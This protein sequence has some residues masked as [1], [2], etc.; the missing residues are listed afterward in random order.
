MS[1]LTLTHERVDDIPLLVKLGQALHLDTAVD[2]CLGTHGL[3]QG[4]SN[5]QLVVVWLAYILSESDHC[6]SRVEEWA[7]RH[8]QTLER[9][10]KHPV[11]RVDF[12]DDRLGNLLRRLSLNDRWE[13]LEQMVWEGEVQVY[14]LGAD[15]VRLDSTTSAGHHQVREKGWMQYG[16]SKDHRPD[17]PQL[18]LMAALAEPAGQWIA[19]DVHP[20][21]RADEGLYLPLYQRVRKI[22]GQQ[23]LLYVGDCKMAPLATRAQMAAQGDY[24][25][26]RLPRNLVSATQWEEWKTRRD[27]M[28]QVTVFWEEEQVVGAG[29]EWEETLSATVGG[30]VITWQERLQWIYSPTLAQQQRQGL[31]QRLQQ[32]REALLALTPEPGRGKRAIRD[33]ETLRSRSTAILERYQVS[34]LLSLQWEVVE[35]R[36]TRYV[37]RG[38]GSTNRPVRDIIRQYYRITG[39]ER[40]TAAIQT[41]QNDFGWQLQITNAPVARLALPQAAAVY[42]NQWHVEHDF[43]RVKA[44]PV[45]L[46]PLFVWRD[47]QVCG[48][49]RLLILAL[50]LLTLIETQVARGLMADA[51]SLSGL[52]EAQPRR[53]TNRPSAVR[54]LRAL[55][56]AE[57]TLTEARSPTHSEWY[58]SPLPPW[59]SQVLAY[60]KLPSDLYESL[61]ENSL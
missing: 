26:T 38:R 39:V 48:L 24:Y 8:R 13:A 53:T 20:G 1:N 9:L 45:G 30:Q 47:D 33:E 15:T 4:L 29:C 56:R 14:A 46:S 60:L 58:L 7:W 49:T 42:R 40:Q 19:S 27:R 54:L 17:L 23:G 35:E 11:R 3:Q 32:A 28:D 61:I 22:L 34:G 50:R 43:H 52:Y 12:S 31:E 21:Q 41:V 2:T 36:Q 18:K 16:H 25:V 44:R 57:I 59:L 51:T 6:K 5:G 10:L 37:G 55:S